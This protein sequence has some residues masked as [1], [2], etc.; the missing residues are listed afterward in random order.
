[1]SC[2]VCTAAILGG[3]H[4]DEEDPTLAPSALGLCTTHHPWLWPRDHRAIS[5][6]SPGGRLCPSCLL[7]A[8]EQRSRCLGACTGWSPADESCTTTEHRRSH[9]FDCS[10]T[11]S[12]LSLLA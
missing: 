2:P 3:D 11:R 6:A 7:L 12:A 1:M 10:D 4:R 5:L 8:D 9:G